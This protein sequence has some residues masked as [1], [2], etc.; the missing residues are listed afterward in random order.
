[1]DTEKIF[2]DF[3]NKYETYLQSLKQLVAV[4]SV[5]FHGSPAAPLEGCAVQLKEIMIRN[6]FKNTRLLQHRARA[7]YVF[8]EMI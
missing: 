7:P 6:G 2:D 8:S 4:P 3:N 5:S 1:M